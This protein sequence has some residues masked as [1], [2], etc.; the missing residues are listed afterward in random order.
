MATRPGKSSTY[1]NP[2]ASSQSIYHS[3]QQISSQMASTL[4]PSLLKSSETQ[5]NS[6][7]KHNSNKF[8]HEGH[9]PLQKNELRGGSKPVGDL[10]EGAKDRLSS[11]QK[12]RNLSTSLN[13]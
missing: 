11:I 8:T 4:N 13:L 9:K 2:R 1:I 10:N 3:S 12:R 5:L 7:L 6:R